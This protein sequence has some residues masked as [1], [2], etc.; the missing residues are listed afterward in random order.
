MTGPDHNL[1]VANY[2]KNEVYRVS[3]ETGAK[4]LLTHS[5][6][7]GPVGMVWNP[8]LQEWYVANYKGNSISRIS[9]EGKTTVLADNLHKPYMLLL[10]NSRQTLYITEQETQS[11]SRLKL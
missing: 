11:I 3:P 1:Y 9:P 5:G 10:D 6:L 8:T 4:T 7:N 2:M